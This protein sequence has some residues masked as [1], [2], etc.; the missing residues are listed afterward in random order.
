M[1]HFWFNTFDS[2]Q[3]KEI[4]IDNCSLNPQSPWPITRAISANCA[5]SPDLLM[6]FSLT[7]SAAAERKSCPTSSLRMTLGPELY[8]P[9][10]S[11]RWPSTAVMLTKWWRTCER[12]MHSEILTCQKHFSNLPGWTPRR[13]TAPPPPACC[14]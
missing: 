4:D 12:Q 14:A 5:S 6:Y 7:N 10:S 9:S 2:W 1:Q 11:T 8:A 13:E 3:V